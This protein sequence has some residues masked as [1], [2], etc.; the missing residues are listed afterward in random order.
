MGNSFDYFVIGWSSSLFRRNPTT[1]TTLTTTFPERHTHTLTLH[2]KWW[3][4]AFLRDVFFPIVQ[5]L[6]VNVYKKSYDSWLFERIFFIILTLISVVF[7]FDFSC[8]KQILPLFSN[9]L[10]DYQEN[11]RYF[12]IYKIIEIFLFCLLS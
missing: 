3:L 8:S 9:D 4:M 2:S 12:H 5:C 7:F 11:N 6:F 10:W 1:T